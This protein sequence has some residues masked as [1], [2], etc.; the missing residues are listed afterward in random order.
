VR[1]YLFSL[2]LFP[3]CTPSSSISLSDSEHP[4]IC[5]W[6]PGRSPYSLKRMIFFQRV[7]F[8]LLVTL[9]F[10]VLSDGVVVVGWVLK[11]AWTGVQI[12][13]VRC[14]SCRVSLAATHYMY[15][16]VIFGYFWLRLAIWVFVEVFGRDWEKSIFR[17][18]VFVGPRSPK[19]LCFGKSKS[20]LPKVS[21]CCCCRNTDGLVCL[22][23]KS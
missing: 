11:A 15:Q 18:K 17:R 23:I 20:D 5:H 9:F 22:D 6:I 2:F 19:T 13:Q 1:Y 21:I 8:I 16:Q 4:I 7:W 3:P 10:L 14:V 12:L